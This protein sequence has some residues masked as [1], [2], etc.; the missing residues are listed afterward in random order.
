M[1]PIYFPFTY[2]PES[3]AKALAA[4]FGKITVY[5]MSGAKVPDDMQNMLDNSILD[6]R[7]P[8]EI[9]GGLLDSIYKDYR[10]WIN[11][12]QGTEIAF[13][14]TM[15]R[16]IPFFDKDAS[17]QIRSELK[18]TTRQIPTHEK[19][20]SLFNAGLFLHMA[21]EYDLENERLSRDLMNIDAMEAD[22]MKDLKG[23]ED[24]IQAGNTEHAAIKF[25]DPGRYMTTE[26]MAAWAPVM[27]KDPQDFG[28]FIT[29]S[30]DVIEHIVDNLPET[31]PIIRFDT[32]PVGADEDD[33]WVNWRNEFMKSLEMLAT[34][35][36]PDA[37]DNITN[38][39][40]VSGSETNVSL[41]LY[42][43]SDKTPRECF[44]GFVDTDALQD[45]LIKTGTGFK[46]TLIGLVE[47]R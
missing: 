44:R 23:E 3:T 43:V 30:R 17:S 37:M 28:L 36:Q 13:L 26:R 31:N 19:P 35:S 7:V 18:K 10:A 1:N 21:Q 11:T 45:D 15:A 4:C 2:I 6:I 39:P 34:H 20:D 46:D 33:T 9:N 47:M 42:M 14:K 41:T 32:V 24:D 22:F 38:P 12:H 25:K 16:K 5:Q 27:L 29:T 40:E 8:M